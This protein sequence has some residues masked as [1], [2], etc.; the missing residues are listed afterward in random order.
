VSMN[1][2]ALV[3]RNQGKYEEVEEV[4][5][6]SLGLR[7]TVL[8][9]EHPSTLASMNNMALVLRNQGKYGEA[10][11]VNRQALGLW[12]TAKVKRKYEVRVLIPMPVTAVTGLAR[13]IP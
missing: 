1:N 2:M 7:E 10:E 6:Q 9:K 12:A 13:T 11:E 8:G 5:R 4:H 3:L